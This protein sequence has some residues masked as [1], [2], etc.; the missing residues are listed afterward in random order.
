[1]HHTRKGKSDE[2]IEEVSG[3]TGLTGGA[4]GWAVLGWRDHH[5]TLQG[6]GRDV[7]PF[8]L[9]VV[10]N[11]DTFRWEYLHDEDTVTD[12]EKV[13]KQDEAVAWLR[14]EL[15]SGEVLK[16]VVEDH[17]RRDGITQRTLRDVHGFVIKRK[18]GFHGPWLWS[19]P[20]YKKSV[21]DQPRKVAAGV[22]TEITATDHEKLAGIVAVI[23]AER[24][25]KTASS[26]RPS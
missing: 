13:T 15:A 8:N 19:L 22:E 2:A 12:S 5:T 25:A 23:D 10:F 21:A 7:A 9:S 18:E 20:D 4:D 26:R 11:P 24:A 6:A 16:S 17:A 1:M 14:K 3:T